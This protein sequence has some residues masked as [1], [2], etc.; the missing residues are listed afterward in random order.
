MASTVVKMWARE[1]NIDLRDVK[2]TGKK[3]RVLKSDIIYYLEDPKKY[4]NGI[5]SDS[6]KLKAKVLP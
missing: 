2:A 5:K 4:S 3:G 6:S 1:H